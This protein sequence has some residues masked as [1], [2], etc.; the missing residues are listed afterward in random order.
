MEREKI[1]AEIEKTKLDQ[2]KTKKE[3]ELLEAEIEKSK[4]A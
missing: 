1:E 4:L 2:V 3:R